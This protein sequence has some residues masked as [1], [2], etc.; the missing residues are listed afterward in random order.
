VKRAIEAM[1]GRILEEQ[2]GYL[3][4]IF[5]SRLFRFVDDLELRLDE[6]AGVIQVRS[7]SRVGHSDF[8]VNRKRVERLRER[9]RSG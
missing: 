4:A 7:A 3:H 9:F 2:P 6:G 5:V 1:G 8:G